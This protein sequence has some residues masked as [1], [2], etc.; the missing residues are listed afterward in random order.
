[1]QTI[2]QA[3]VLKN[4]LAVTLD[5]GISLSLFFQRVQDGPDHVRL[6]DGNS[7]TVCY[8]VSSRCVSRSLPQ[9]MKSLLLLS[10]PYKLFLRPR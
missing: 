5:L 1:M 6:V 7:E 9:A 8:A 2:L 4:C 3:R 10:T